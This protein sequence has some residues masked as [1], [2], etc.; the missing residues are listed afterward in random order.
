MKKMASLFLV[1]ALLGCGVKGYEYSFVDEG[2][3]NQTVYVDVEVSQ[4]L[5]KRIAID[6]TYTTKD[7][8][9]TTKKKLKDDYNMKGSSSI[10]KEWYEQIEF[11]EKQLVGSD[12]NLVLDETGKP[13]DEDVL[14]GCTIYL[15]EIMNAVHEAM[16]QK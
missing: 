7:G 9:I 16:N 6:E 3:H 15:T 13:S 8:K 5:I 11:L 1:F 12:G 14:A 10:G 2:N 4:G